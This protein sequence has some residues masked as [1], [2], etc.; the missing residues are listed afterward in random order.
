MDA[1]LDQWCQ[2]FAK[3]PVP[4]IGNLLGGRLYMGSFEPLEPSEILLHAR[5][6]LG[7]GGQER[8]DGALSEWLQH[9]I[10]VEKAADLGYGNPK[11]FAR[12]L[13]Q[14]FYAAATMN[15]RQTMRWLK[16]EKIQGSMQD[17][18]AEYFFG[19]T[20]DPLG[21]YYTSLSQ[22]QEDRRLLRL[23]LDLAALNTGGFTHHGRM[24]LDGLLRMPDEGRN[25]PA[26]RV[27]ESLLVGV[28]RFANGLAHLKRI[29]DKKILDRYVEFLK[30][31]YPMSDK[32]WVRKLS[33]ARQRV[34]MHKLA[35]QWLASH[36]PEVFSEGAGDRIRQNLSPFFS[37]KSWKAM[38]ARVQ[39]EPLAQ[40][41]PDLKNFFDRYRRHAHETGDSHFLVR[42][43]NNFG[44]RILRKDPV[45]V[46]ELAQDAATWEPYDSHSWS[47]LGRALDEA[48]DWPR[49][50]AV[51][52]QARR[53]FPYNAKLHNQLGDTLAHRGE[54]D[55]AVAVLDDAVRF[56]PDDV[57]IHA[58]KA[59]AR[60]WGGE[61]GEALA[62]FDKIVQRF[63]NKLEGYLGK[64]EIL[65]VQGKLE[66]AD[67]LLE[68][69]RSVAPD[70]PELSRKENQLR[71]LQNGQKLPFQLTPRPTGRE[72]S[73]DTLAQITGRNFSYAPAL[74][75]TTAFRR[76]GRHDAAKTHLAHVNHRNEHRSEMG[77]QIWQER[78]VAEAADYFT[79]QLKHH[80]HDGVLYLHQQRAY[81]R[82]QRPVAEWD[83]LKSRF[84]GMEAMILTE[85]NG[86]VVPRYPTDLDADQGNRLVTHEDQKR[87]WLV[88]TVDRD[89]GLLDPVEEDFMA[90]SRA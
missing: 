66:E 54:T 24:G 8:L 30:G 42:T 48:G 37:E 53:R 67:T 58:T 61:T 79:E 16:D 65:M 35:E 11:S 43:F 88:T 63:P 29:D 59:Y 45:W 80:P 31:A 52:W 51:L 50:E 49:C 33:E 81:R 72:S 46:A 9:V 55:A 12:M 40:L 56:F 87:S 83:H 47:L 28:L 57:I 3:E 13:M 27:S 74:G 90:A 68:L 62:E 84:P 4:S 82:L 73:P 5:G 10:Q 85:K 1:Q 41:K 71:K 36:F 26:G 20:C 18:L 23:W 22:H 70:H 38:L 69:A 86:G 34:P 76:A 15:L 60:L 6:A 2:H 78:G 39:R 25:G 75:R 89:R 14:S 64:A 17:F 32:A 21:A 7:S 77:L 19:R 44:N